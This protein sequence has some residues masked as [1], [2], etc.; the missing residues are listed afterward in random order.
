MRTILCIFLSFLV[1]QG[2]TCFS[3]QEVIL[4]NLLNNYSPNDV[5]N[6]L[7][8][9]SIYP[10]DITPEYE[11]KTKKLWDNIVYL[12]QNLENLKKSHASDELIKKTEALLNRMREEFEAQ[13]TPF[14]IKTIKKVLSELL[15][16]VKE[17]KYLDIVIEYQQDREANLQLLVDLIMNAIINGTKFLN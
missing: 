2:I 8:N 5:L 9:N 6:S 11:G 17:E 7:K 13:K 16:N 4:D 15:I 1:I 10:L 14:V 3:K 12:E